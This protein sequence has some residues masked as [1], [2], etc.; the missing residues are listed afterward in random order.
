VEVGLSTDLGHHQY[1]WSFDCVAHPST[2]STLSPVRSTWAVDFCR[3]NVES[4][5]NIWLCHQ[6]VPGFT[7]CSVISIVKHTWYSD[8]NH[9][10]FQFTCCC[11]NAVDNELFYRV[12]QKSGPFH[13]TAYNVYITHTGNFCNMSTVYSQTLRLTLNHVAVSGPDQHRHYS[14]RQ[15]DNPL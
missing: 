3:L 15:H 2:L 11:L 7:V 6:C 4:C 10:S 14:C 9:C 1:S 5:F 8:L 13:F 12:V